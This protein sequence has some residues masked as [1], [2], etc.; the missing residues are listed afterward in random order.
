MPFI[1]FPYPDTRCAGISVEIEDRPRL[2]GPRMQ[3]VMFQIAALTP[4]GG[5]SFVILYRSR[6]Y[7]Q[8]AG[9]EGR[10]LCECR[11]HDRDDF[12]HRVAGRADRSATGRTRVSTAEASVGVFD[13]EVLACGDVQYLAY[14]FIKGGCRSRF[15]AWRDLTWMFEDE[16]N[17]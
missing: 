13:N 10:Y 5:P 15:F 17:T 8:V 12:R 2:L 9:G 1:C 16:A 6:D 7:L 11:H 14:A 4:E 3:R